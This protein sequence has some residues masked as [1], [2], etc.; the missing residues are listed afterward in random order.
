MYSKDYF[1]GMLDLTDA[2]KYEL[3]RKCEYWKI[4]AMKC[5]DIDAYR[6]YINIAGGIETAT[7]IIDKVLTMQLEVKGGDNDI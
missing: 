7:K 5:D 4:K 6:D 3:A 1:L 2:I